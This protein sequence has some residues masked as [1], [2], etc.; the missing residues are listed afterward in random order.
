MSL[1]NKIK[2]KVTEYIDLQINLLKINLIERSSGILAYI[3]Y[4]IVILFIL[5]ALLLF[6]CLGMA[7]AFAAL[8][9]S[10]TL[11]Y[12]TAFGVYFLFFIV[13]FLTRKSITRRL[14][15]RFIRLMTDQDGNDKTTKQI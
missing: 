13:I 3:I 4:L 14:R 5:L 11:G 10:R 12:F 9:N 8:L 7:E 2:E 15:N 6:F 1:L